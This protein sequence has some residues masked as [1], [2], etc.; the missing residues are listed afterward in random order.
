MGHRARYTRLVAPKLVCRQRDPK[1]TLTPL[2]L[3]QI[4]EAGGLELPTRFF[5]FV[6]E[7]G[8]VRYEAPLLVGEDG[9]VFAAGTMN[10]VANFAQG[11]GAGSQTK[12]LED[13][14]EASLHA[15]REQHR[16]HG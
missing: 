2:E 12:E 15:Y 13:A 10:V 9:P 4:E 7:R 8:V 14:L 16:T 11:G 5:E 3:E 6:D 1:R